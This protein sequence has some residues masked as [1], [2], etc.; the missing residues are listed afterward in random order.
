M[1]DIAK[2]GGTLLGCNNLRGWQMTHK[3][4]LQCHQDTIIPYQPWVRVLK[5]INNSDANFL[6]LDQ[7]T[8]K[9]IYSFIIIFLKKRRDNWNVVA[10]FYSCGFWHESKEQLQGNNKSQL[11]ISSR[12]STG[13]K[14]S[15]LSRTWRETEWTFVTMFTGFRKIRQ[16]LEFSLRL[17][18][19]NKSLQFSGF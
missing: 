17:E 10:Q 18:E 2:H 3:F 5:W 15:C 9:G 7:D 11:M 4:T 8:T 6:L 14:D 1:P 12:A 19:F 13:L 16:W